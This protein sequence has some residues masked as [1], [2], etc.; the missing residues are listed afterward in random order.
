[1]NSFVAKQPNGLYCIYSTGIDNIVEYN[2]TEEDYIQYMMNKA[3]EEATIAI[4]Q[5]KP[6]EEVTL[7]LYP[8]TRRDLKGMNKILEEC[9]SQTLLKEEDYEFREPNLYNKGAV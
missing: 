1:M 4:E 8:D 5:A 7:R 2:M 3:R 6:F 9:G